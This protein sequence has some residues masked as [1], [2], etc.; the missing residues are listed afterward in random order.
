MTQER[1]NIRQEVAEF[2]SKHPIFLGFM[3]VTVV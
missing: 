3:G 2:N 1:T